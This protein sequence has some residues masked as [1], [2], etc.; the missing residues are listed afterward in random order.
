MKKRIVLI[1]GGSTGLGY[2]AASRLKKM[3]YHVYITSRQA[4]KAAA[5]AKE[6]A[7]SYVALDVTDEASIKQAAE[8]IQKQEGCID[9]L[10]NN[11]GIPGGY[12]KPEE[13]D[14][15]IMRT[16]MIQMFLA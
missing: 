2:T 15:A 3:G 10:I 4:A 14:A 16:V 11:A 12:G 8:T 9:I 6:L 5:A 1:T 13:I 7:V